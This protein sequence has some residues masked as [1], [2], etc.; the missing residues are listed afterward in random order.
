D[1]VVGGRGC[2][3]LTRGMPDSE[4]SDCAVPATCQ[5]RLYRPVRLVI[6]ELQYRRAGRIQR[7]R[8]RLLACI[9][10]LELRNA[11]GPQRAGCQTIAERLGLGRYVVADVIV[12]PPEPEAGPLAARIGGGPA[13]AAAGRELAGS[14]GAQREIVVEDVEAFRAVLGDDAGA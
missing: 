1:Q 9:G 10:A 2:K 6:R 4:I 12:G 7:N 14:V 5:T 8:L 13:V 3:S 11:Y